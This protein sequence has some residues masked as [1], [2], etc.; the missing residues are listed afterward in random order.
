MGHL[1]GNDYVIINYLCPLIAYNQGY[2]GLGEHGVKFRQ[3]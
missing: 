1:C 2:E 3:P